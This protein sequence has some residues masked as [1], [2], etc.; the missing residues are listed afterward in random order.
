VDEGQPGGAR[1]ETFWSPPENRKPKPR[2]KAGK[3]GQTKGPVRRPETPRSISPRSEEKEKDGQRGAAGII[4]RTDTDSGSQALDGGDIEVEDVVEYTTVSSSI[5][6]GG[7]EPPEDTIDQQDD[8]PLLE[9]T[10]PL[11]FAAV[12]LER[13]RPLR[14]AAVEEV[15]AIGGE[16]LDARPKEGQ[17]GGARENDARAADRG[18]PDAPEGEGDL[19]NHGTTPAT[20]GS[21][22]G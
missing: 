4:G 3:K 6:S 11:R 14:F 15:I 12:E 13:T 1:S 5:L 16:P 8:I 19:Q 18:D 20:G 2:A 22:T 21:A 10:R 7:P 9:R 17:S